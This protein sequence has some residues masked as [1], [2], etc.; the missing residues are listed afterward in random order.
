MKNIKTCFIKMPQFLTLSDC[1]IYEQL[2][3]GR[4]KA[5]SRHLLHLLVEPPGGPVPPALCA[6]FTDNLP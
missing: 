2:P 1:V 3:V 4:S 5:E 6:S